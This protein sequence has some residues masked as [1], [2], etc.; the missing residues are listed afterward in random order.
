L[1][2]P[3]TVWLPGRVDL[4]NAAL[5]NS[6]T[7]KQQPPEKSDLDGSG[8]ESRIPEVN[9]PQHIIHKGVEWEKMLGDGRLRSLS[10]IARKEKLTR[11]RVT[12]IMN[13]LKL[14][15][16]WREFLATLDA[17]EE[18][19]R[20]S[21]RKLRN[22]RSSSFTDKP[23]T[24]RR[25]PSTDAKGKT[26][27]RSR[28][29]RKQPPEI[30]VVETDEPLARPDLRVLEELIQKAALRKLKEAEEKKNKGES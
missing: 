27:G 10:D 9:K 15:L 7:Y 19:R 5:I 11:A 22:Y 4:R 17:P 18:I 2:N 21:E 29:K 24:I 20:Y 14:P 26:P 8:T 6:I 3:F 16:A 23:P 13:L 30:I 1:A 28:T 25:K 12:Q